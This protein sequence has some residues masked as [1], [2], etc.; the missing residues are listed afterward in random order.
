MYCEGDNYLVI[1]DCYSKWLEIVKIKSKSAETINEV[2]CDLFSR[3]GFPDILYTDN[4]PFNS[5]VCLKLANEGNFKYIF[6]SPTYPQ[7]NGQAER[8]VGIAKQIVTKAKQA[9]EDYK[10]GL[11]NYRNTPV[12]ILNASPSQLLNSR[13][14]KSKIPMTEETL[15]PKIQEDVT[16]K[17]EERQSNAEK[18]YNKTARRKKVSFEENQKVLFH[19]GK[20]W[21]P[22]VIGRKGQN[23]RSY[24]IKTNQ[25]NYVRTTHHL[26]DRFDNRP[27]QS[28]NYYQIYGQNK[29]EAISTPPERPTQRERPIPAQAR[30][31]HQERRQPETEQEAQRPENPQPRRSARTPK[32]NPKYVEK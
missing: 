1:V 17:L 5:Q 24:E 8:A 21:E 31:K 6:S 29:E 15:K 7:S 23:P 16:N 2:L 14:L 28:S 30:H 4:N 10:M 27:I 9:K 22:A 18:Q 19:T 32:Q 26:R 25:G 3:Y 13:M 20:T 12:N 11:L